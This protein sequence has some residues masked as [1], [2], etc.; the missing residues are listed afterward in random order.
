MIASR[1][2]GRGGSARTLARKPIHRLNEPRA[3]HTDLASLSPI[4]SPAPPA[5][6]RPS[7]SPLRARPRRELAAT[8]P[9][10]LV[11]VQVPF[12]H[13]LGLLFALRATEAYLYP[14]PF[15]QVGTDSFGRHYGEA[16]TRPPLFDSRAR[17]FEWDHDRWTL[18]VLGHGLLGAELY[19]RPR[20]CGWSPLAALAFA[21]G[22]SA[23]WEYAFEGNSVRPSAL[24]L[25]YTPLAG[26]V[27]GEGRYWGVRFVQS[28]GNRTVR[29]IGNA[30][31]DP[32]GELERAAGAPC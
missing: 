7:L 9:P 3:V 12:T 27:L 19:Y 5:S 15:A 13:S 26:M 20:R 21:T 24:D 29:T 11:D 16:V 23:A 6:Q 10:E 25:V 17:A 4:A 2:Q 32:F 8:P 18:N 28:L 22:A 30:L 31:L 1:T 14:N